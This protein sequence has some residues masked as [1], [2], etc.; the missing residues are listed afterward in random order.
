MNAGGEFLFWILLFGS[1]AVMCVVHWVACQV[2]KLRDARQVIARQAL[3][4]QR[5]QECLHIGPDNW[6][7]SAGRVRF[8]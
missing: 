5:F 1:I 6:T 3:T 8:P 4:I 7:V 2:I